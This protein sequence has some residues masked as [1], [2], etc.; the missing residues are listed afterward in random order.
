MR[1]YFYLSISLI[2][3]VILTLCLINIKFVEILK[4]CILMNHSNVE[5]TLHLLE[6]YNTIEYE[7][8]FYPSCI[9]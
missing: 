9:L 4:F 8:C 7:N 1:I 6:Y 2:G 3:S 5:H